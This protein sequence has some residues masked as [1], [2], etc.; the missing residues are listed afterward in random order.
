MKINDSA[1]NCP[2]GKF[3]TPTEQ[4]SMILTSS[5]PAV[6]DSTIVFTAVLIPSN[7]SHGTTAS[8]SNRLVSAYERRKFWSCVI[9]ENWKHRLSMKSFM[10]IVILALTWQLS[11]WLWLCRLIRV[12]MKI[13]MSEIFTAAELVLW[14]VF[15]KILHTKKKTFWRLHLCGPRFLFKIHFILNIMRI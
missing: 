6:L 7:V 14:S 2:C 4:Y 11:H 15:W 10:A 8:Q 1:F 9:W 5:S 12:K 13:M 3:Y